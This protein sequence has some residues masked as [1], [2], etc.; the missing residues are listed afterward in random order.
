[1][2]L[3]R[4][5]ERLFRVALEKILMINKEALEQIRL[6][7]QQYIKHWGKKVDYSVLPMGITQEKLV[8]VLERIVHTGESILVGYSKI[9]KGK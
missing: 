1:M 5:N 2:W 3:E 4:I 9:K 6:L 7:E 8:K